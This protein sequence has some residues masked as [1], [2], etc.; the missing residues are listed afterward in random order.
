MTRFIRIIPDP[1]PRADVGSRIRIDY[2]PDD[3]G[4][5]CISDENVLPEKLLDADCYRVQTIANI[6][7]DRPKARAIRD[8]MVGLCK[9]LDE[10]E[11]QS[12]QDRYAQA[13]FETRSIVAAA[14]GVPLSA[15]QVVTAEPQIAQRCPHGN[16][17]REA[18][19]GHW[20][21]WH[22]GH[23]CHLDPNRVNGK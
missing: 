14:H 5:F 7:M 1:D 4:A 18:G 9:H 6:E 3:T 13:E 22:R 8:A 19:A 23:G 15:V 10:E 11:R 16:M 2:D 12:V 21:D 20:Q 17:P